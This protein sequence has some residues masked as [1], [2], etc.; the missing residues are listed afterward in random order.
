MTRV[1]RGVTSRYALMSPEAARRLEGQ[2]ERRHGH[3]DTGPAPLMVVASHAAGAVLCLL[4]SR[5]ADPAAPLAFAVVVAL[6]SAPFI[7][8]P[9]IRKLPT[10]WSQ[11]SLVFGAGLLGWGP[12]FG[13]SPAWVAVVALAACAAL[14]AWQQLPTLRLG[15]ALA[16]TA[17]GLGLGVGV[18]A[19]LGPLAFFAAGGWAIIAMQQAW[20]R[21]EGWRFGS[22]AAAAAWLLVGLLDAAILLAG[23]A[24]DSAILLL[25]GILVFGCSAAWLGVVRDGVPPL[26]R[27]GK[28]HDPRA[29]PQP[30][31][32]DP[33]KPV[34]TA[35]LKPATATLKPATAAL[36]PATAALKPPTAALKPPTAA[37]QP[38]TAA[39]RPATAAVKPPVAA[40]RTEAAASPARG[41]PAPT[42]RA[43]PSAVP[44]TPPARR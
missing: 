29:H 34:A 19:P 6:G 7:L 2:L 40:L 38:V 25:A 3:V 28:L 39:L 41:A 22:V 42:S 31:R 43:H 18:G 23:H 17:A 12:A 14:A 11:L 20:R 30:G 35:A 26:P 1:F 16:W 15:I 21:L 5:A 4:L 33:A 8:A 13:G 27:F 9:L 32:R 44:S 10:M 36:K 37:L 24:S